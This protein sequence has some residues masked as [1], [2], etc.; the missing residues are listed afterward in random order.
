[1]ILILFALALPAA[2]CTAGLRIYWPAAQVRPMGWVFLACLGTGVGIGFAS[3]YFF[4]WYPAFGHPNSGFIVAELFALGALA[5]LL[6]QYLKRPHKKGQPVFLETPPS[7]WAGR[8]WVP[9]TVLAILATRYVWS[10]YLAEPHGYWDAY[11][12]WNVRARYLYRGT[13]TWRDAFAAYPLQDHPDYPLF[14]PATIA[15]C[16]LY[17]GED[18]TLAPITV[19]FLMAVLTAGVLIS[20]LSLLRGGGQGWVAGMALI[21]S[22]QYVENIGIQYAD[23]PL[24]FFI[25]ASAIA[26]VFH[27]RTGRS[28]CLFPA[29]AGM[30]AGLA[31]WTK[32]EGL[33]FLAA[34]VGSRGAVALFGPG[35]R[36]FLREQGWFLL[37]LLPIG[38]TILYFKVEFAP[39]NDLVAGQKPAT[40][41]QIADWSRH[42]LI[43]KEFASAIWNHGRYMLLILIAYTV[44]VGRPPVSRR[45]PGIA[46]IFVLLLSVAAGY[47][48]IY[49]TTPYELS[50]HLMTS[51]H[52][53]IVQLW[54]LAL[55]GY[56]L[57]VATPDEA[58]KVVPSD[59]PK[60]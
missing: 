17:A 12:F 5:T 25:V 38:L 22:H 41:G 57:A 45:G 37:G 24:A 3:C 23:V 32:N 46:F 9:F 47:Y 26:F 20:G 18:D 56:F 55:L 11:A 51:L 10:Y 33:L 39:P 31:A 50:W 48:L 44:L 43:L 58:G 14:L 36:P 28:S 16:W 21:G 6:Y 29:L 1:M 8:L 30:L 4:L 42:E 60:S 7:L 34:I 40:L 53:L 49:L 2:I 15:R 19:A 27:D 35:I 52:R 59:P 13:E 54:P